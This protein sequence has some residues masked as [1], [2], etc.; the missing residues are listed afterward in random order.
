MG[1]RPGSDWP[2]RAA[3]GQAEAG[4]V[5]RGA[6]AGGSGSCPSGRG[7]VGRG[8]RGGA[9]L[10]WR[11]AGPGRAGPGPAVGPP[12]PCPSALP[13]KYSV[14]VE[15]SELLMF[16]SSLTALMFVIKLFQCV[17]S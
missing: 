16:I 9:W 11:R 5:P 8:V 12:E 7:Q 3:V 6:G 14:F 10:P 2:L 15:M 4:A 1:A 17:N 13:G